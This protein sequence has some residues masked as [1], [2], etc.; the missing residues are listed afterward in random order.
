MFEKAT[1][2]TA[3]D[4]S[5]KQTEVEEASYSHGSP[6]TKHSVF[7]AIKSTIK[8][9]TNLVCAL[10]VLRNCGYNWFEFV[11]CAEEEMFKCGYNEGVLNQFLIGFAGQLSELG[12]SKEEEKLVEHTR[13]AFL[14][15]RREEE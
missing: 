15:L 13:Q 1:D 10:D 12:L 11:A 8:F 6:S 4:N 7:N 3:P 5:N 9:D 14:A 2:N